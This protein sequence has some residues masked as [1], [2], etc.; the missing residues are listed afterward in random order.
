[1]QTR[2]PNA[3]SDSSAQFH[4][5]G[6][7]ASVRAPLRCPSYDVELAVLGLSPPR[8]CRTPDGLRIALHVSLA[9]VALNGCLPIDT[10]IDLDGGGYTEVCR[11]SQR[12]LGQVRSPCSATAAVDHA[13]A[14]VPAL[15]DAVDRRSVPF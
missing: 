11:F 9:V 13:S 1:M 15:R 3:G 14:P 4:E 6:R 5:D 12:K 7:E 10:L 8:L 2:R